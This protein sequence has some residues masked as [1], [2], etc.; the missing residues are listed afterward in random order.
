MDHRQLDLV[1]ASLAGRGE[2]A[3]VLAA[4]LFHRRLFYLA[5]G[6]RRCFDDDARARNAAFLSF[7]RAVVADLDR[8]DRLMP[9]LSAL[10]RAADRAG[11]D[12]AEHDAVREALFFALRMA[13]HEGLT[14]PLYTAWRSTFDK[15]AGVV[16]SSSASSPLPAPSPPSRRAGARSGT[17]RIAEAPESVDAD[18][19]PPSARAAG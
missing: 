13:M 7:A 15:L 4:D 12:P 6:L 8:F 14:L 1:R 19:I 18:S 9:R 16:R 10:S 11:V 2:N 17:H 5:P 3:L